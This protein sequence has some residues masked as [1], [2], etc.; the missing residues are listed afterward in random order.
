MFLILLLFKI[1]GECT[2]KSTVWHP[3]SNY[4]RAHLHEEV[5][6]PH[7]VEE[8]A[9]AL[10]LVPVILLEVEEGHD[11]RM[12]G[13]EVYR[14]RS[15]ALS[16]ALP[17]SIAVLGIF[18]GR[19]CTPREKK[20]SDASVTSSGKNRQKSLREEG[21]NCVKRPQHTERQREAKTQCCVPLSHLIDVACG[22][23]EHSEHGHDTV[24]RAVRSADVRVR[25]SHVVDRETDAAGMFGDLS[26]LQ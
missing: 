1:G 2:R 20:V 8:V 5:G 15:F 26:A 7:C 21:K 14:N 22:V 19:L 18:G 3:A 25:R 4:Y 17:L 9:C 24:R 11:V 16:S 23:V 13:F 10:K 12:P 6:D